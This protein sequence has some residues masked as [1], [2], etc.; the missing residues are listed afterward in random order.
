MSLRI[1][2]GRNL[3]ADWYHK[4]P[5]VDVAGKLDAINVGSKACR[6]FSDVTFLWG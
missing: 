5:A 6:H 2:V 1:D 3:A 4:V